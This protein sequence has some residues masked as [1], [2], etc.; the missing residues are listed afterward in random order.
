MPGRRTF[1]V[2]DE[3]F[4]SPNSST[5]PCIP[6]FHDSLPEYTMPRDTQQLSWSYNAYPQLA[7]VPREN[8][9][10]GPIFQR[11]AYTF[12]NIPM[13]R[14]GHLWR[15][16]RSVQTQWE[17]LETALIVIAS[18]LIEYS[19]AFMPLDFSTFR[20]PSQYGCRAVG[21]ERYARKI[22]MRCRDAFIPLMSLCSFAISLH[23]P[24]QQ[25]SNIGTPSWARLLIEKRGL[26]PE[27]VNSLRQSV[28]ADF[29][30]N[31]RVGVIVHVGKC[32]WLSQIKAMLLAE[33]P[34]WFYWGRLGSLFS[35]DHPVSTRYR[36]TS[37]EI[38]AEQAR[39]FPSTGQ[40]ADPQSEASHDREDD[41]PK[42]ERFS[43]QKR[44][45]TWQEFF[46]RHVEIRSRKIA[47]E[48]PQE[49]QKRLDREQNARKHAAPSRRGH[50][51]AVYHWSE[52]GQFRIR[53][54]VFRA[55][56]E[57]IWD[58]YS[59]SQ[60]KYDSI[61]NEWDICSEFDPDGR[62]EADESLSDFD[63]YEDDGLAYLPR[64]ETPPGPPPY[65]PKSLSPSPVVP[66]SYWH[67]DLLEMYD[68][69]H[70][71]VRLDIPT[72]DDM[73]FNRYGFDYT[74]ASYDEI[75]PD[76]KKWD[77]VRKIL[78]DRDAC[79]SFTLCAPIIDFVTQLLA[80]SD[81]PSLPGSIWDLSDSSRSSLRLH[82]N[83]NIVV[84][85]E[86]FNS[87][88]L[89]CI[90]PIGQ[91]SDRDSQW[92]LLVDSAATAVQCLRQCWGP[93]RHDVARRLLEMGIPFRTLRA[94]H[95]LPLPRQPSGPY[96]GL[97]WR[98][99]AYKPDLVDYASYTSAR[100]ALLRLPHARAALLK[101]GILWRLAMEALEAN[102]ALQGPSDIVYSHGC[103]ITSSTGTRLWDDDLTQDESE[104]IC[105]VYKVYTGKHEYPFVVH[106][107]D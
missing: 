52:E 73:L 27:W 45:E 6:H 83:P 46:A 92:L 49:R 25:T 30:P 21:E 1:I 37:D 82:A 103:S 79:I 18:F 9:F 86:L 43:R 20:L 69:G 14:D 48:T 36:P 8:R 7:F 31:T 44:G 53:T 19:Y 15:L 42:P 3:V 35:V 90:E 97:G 12:Y 64:A 57:D 40:M 88:K 81:R 61:H 41:I 67:D 106:C 101:G 99:Q 65:Q 59:D 63:R 70:S 32:Q 74:D 72:L 16:S 95:H 98:S 47:T 104:L 4:S 2:N 84:S 51:P 75:Q 94:L 28:V 100:N 60:R 68:P 78:L 66:P 87:G 102:D 77:N 11:L 89:Y 24:T 93:S 58:C 80:T 13:E 96:I 71:D 105:G 56:V 107:H 50:G 34:V 62:P 54:R 38:L 91:Q 55:C 22:A 33:V 39:R 23:L 10:E 17:R 29:S 5:L 85:P 26:H 76:P